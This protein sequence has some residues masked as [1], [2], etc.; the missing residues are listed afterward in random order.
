[1]GD[2][3]QWIYDSRNKRLTISEKLRIFKQIAEAMAFL[4]HFKGF[5]TTS[6]CN[7][8]THQS[9]GVVHR[10]LRTSN[11]LLK[12]G[13]EELSVRVSAFYKSREVTEFMT[14][15]DWTYVYNAPETF[16]ASYGK[17]ADVFSFG[18][19]FFV[20]VF[21]LLL[22]YLCISSGVIM[23]EVLKEA[24]PPVRKNPITDYAFKAVQRPENIDE[25]LWNI[26]VKC[27]CS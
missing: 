20:S 27:V 21:I 1:M 7:C 9:I 14:V 3:H 23:W 4:H 18:I 2:L 24:S 6:P 26:V 16:S 25:K 17:P 19:C 11:I 12:G 15:M 5:N 22:T 13:A 10:N 8:T